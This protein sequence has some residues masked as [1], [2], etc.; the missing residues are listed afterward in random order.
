MRFL[1]NVN[2]RFNAADERFAGV[3]KSLEEL[4]ALIKQPA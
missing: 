1:D 2:E 4:K 3:E